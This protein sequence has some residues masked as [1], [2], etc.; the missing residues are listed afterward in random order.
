MSVRQALPSDLPTIRQTLELHARTESSMHRADWAIDQLDDAVFGTDAFVHVAI[1]ERDGAFAG[2]AMWHRTF[3]SWART[4]GIW[5][6][7]LYVVEAHRRSG[8]ARELMD[9]LR[10]PDRRPHRVGRDGRKRHRGTLLRRAWARSQCL[11]SPAT[12]G[13]K[14]IRSSQTPDATTLAVILRAPHAL[15]DETYLVALQL[16]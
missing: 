14:T 10:G 16:R 13:S 15:D 11:T 4:S 8:V 2:L 3:S 6:E 12:A 7:D 5:L 9:H 1:A